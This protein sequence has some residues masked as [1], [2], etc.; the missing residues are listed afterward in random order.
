[1]QSPLVVPRAT[2]LLAAAHVRNRE[3]EAA[4]EQAEA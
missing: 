3:N 1:M 2:H 4:I